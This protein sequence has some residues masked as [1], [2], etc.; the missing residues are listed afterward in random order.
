MTVTL[1]EKQYPEIEELVD[2]VSYPERDIQ[3]TSVVAEKKEERWRPDLTAT[4]KN[5][6]M[7]FIEIR[8]THKVGEEKK[9]D[10]DNLLEVDLSK[11]K[12]STGALSQRSG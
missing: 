1:V 9:L 7:M 8:V 11:V 4:L 5:E 6:A 3:L 12:T 10:L 2:K